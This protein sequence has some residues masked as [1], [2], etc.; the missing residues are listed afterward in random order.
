VDAAAVVEHNSSIG[1]EFTN[2][3]MKTQIILLWPYNLN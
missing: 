2:G 1:Q 3:F